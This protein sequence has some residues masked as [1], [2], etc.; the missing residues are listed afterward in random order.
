MAKQSV[1]KRFMTVTEAAE[2]LSI[3]QQYLRLLIRDGRL[4]PGIVYRPIPGGH[5]KVDIAAFDD[6]VKNGCLTIT[7]DDGVDQDGQV[8]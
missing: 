4:P 6:W 2:R 8:A 3:T 5:Y 7:P 1:T